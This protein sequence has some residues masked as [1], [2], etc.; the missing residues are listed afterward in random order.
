MRAAS[1]AV[2]F[3]DF[4]GAVEQVICAGARFFIGNPGSSVS[5]G[6]LNLR[7]DI[8]G[9]AEPYYMPPP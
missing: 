4:V 8:L 9:R 3:G 6:V 1:D 2:V 7:Q 5:G